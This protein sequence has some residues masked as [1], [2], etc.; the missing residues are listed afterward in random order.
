MQ[1][2]TVDEVSDLLRVHRGR[3]YE[4]V[5]AGGLPVV[6][7]GRQIRVSGEALERWIEQGGQ[8]L[9]GGWRREAPA[10]A[11]SSIINA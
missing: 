10:D 9:P 2:L 11:P 5:R 4:L 8:A 1:L 6:R 7:L 3:V